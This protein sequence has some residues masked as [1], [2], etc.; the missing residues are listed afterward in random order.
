[1]WPSVN[2]A[3][4]LI[5]PQSSSTQT[6]I[7]VNSL[8][9]EFNETLVT[10]LSLDI[11]TIANFGRDASDKEKLHGSFE[12][13]TKALFIYNP[14]LFIEL[15]NQNSEETDARQ[16]PFSCS[17]HTLHERNIQS[18]YSNERHDRMQ[19]V[20]RDFRFDF[21]ANLPQAKSDHICKQA[22]HLLCD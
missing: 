15:A 22:D 10:F 7:S 12:S 2:S 8:A 4:F 9:P 20:L 5:L 16:E 17:L 13:S 11:E 19:K 3:R 1:M 14:V 6:S 18:L 21:N